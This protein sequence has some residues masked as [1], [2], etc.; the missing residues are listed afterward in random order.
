MG[1]GL[2]GEELRKIN[3]RNDASNMDI[4]KGIT[5]NNNNMGGGTIKN[6]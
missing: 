2:E 4:K 5:M 6:D 1:F 3:K